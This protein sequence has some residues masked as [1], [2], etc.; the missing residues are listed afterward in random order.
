MQFF[1]HIKK[2]NLILFYRVGNYGYFTPP[3]GSPIVNSCIPYSGKIA[4]FTG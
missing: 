3:K 2:K 4:R 1:L